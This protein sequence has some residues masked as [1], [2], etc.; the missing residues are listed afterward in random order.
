MVEL[1]LTDGFYVVFQKQS[2]N[3]LLSEENVI[4]KLPNSKIPVLHLQER[5]FTSIALSKQDAEHYR[6]YKMMS[7]QNC[8]L[9]V[10]L[11]QTMRLLDD[12][13]VALN[14]MTVSESIF[15]MKGVQAYI[16]FC[17]NVSRIQVLSSPNQ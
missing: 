7:S 12:S 11:I 2:S 14:E 13:Y 3:V 16:P 1:Y 8:A 9:L 15:Y 10:S 4:Q 5:D 6:I 17:K